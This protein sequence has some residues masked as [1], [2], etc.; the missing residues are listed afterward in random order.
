MNFNI[1]CILIIFLGSVST[2]L[3]SSTVKA[4]KILLLYKSDSAEVWNIIKSPEIQVKYM[5]EEPSIRSIQQ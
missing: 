1:Q 2:Q 3:L 4:R 5:P